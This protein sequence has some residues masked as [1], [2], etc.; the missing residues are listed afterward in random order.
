MKKKERRETAA[1][2]RGKGRLVRLLTYFL[3]REKRA[4]SQITQHER[5]NRRRCMCAPSVTV[6][7]HVS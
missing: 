6:R 5:K 7:V 2:I 4:T 3:S 1:S